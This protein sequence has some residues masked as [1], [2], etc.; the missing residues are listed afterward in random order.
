MKALQWVRRF[1]LLLLCF[2]CGIIADNAMVE[3]Q[4]PD[5]EIAMDLMDA[6][7]SQQDRSLQ[8]CNP[9][10]SGSTYNNMFYENELW[11]SPN[12]PH[13][14]IVQWDLIS[15]RLKL[16][17][18]YQYLDHWVYVWW[19]NTYN[20]Y[21]AKVFH[22]LGTAKSAMHGTL[23]HQDKAIFNIRNG[24]EYRT[25]EQIYY[26]GYQP[27]WAQY[28]ANNREVMKQV[29]IAAGQQYAFEHWWDNDVVADLLNGNMARMLKFAD[30][31]RIV[32]YKSY[33][34]RIVSKNQIRILDEGFY[35]INR[36][37]IDHAQGYRLNNDFALAQEFT[38]GTNLNSLDVCENH[39]GTDHYFPSGSTVMLCCGL[40]CTGD[41]DNDDV[42][43]SIQCDITISDC[44][45]SLLEDCV[46]KTMQCEK[47]IKSP[48]DNSNDY[49]S[50][51]SNRPEDNLWKWFCSYDCPGGTVDGEVKKIENA[52]SVEVRKQIPI[53]HSQA[54]SEGIY[55]VNFKIKRENVNVN[56]NEVLAVL[57]VHSWYNQ[58]T[59]DEFHLRKSD[60]KLGNTWYTIEKEVNLYRWDWHDI[61]LSVTGVND[62]PDLWVDWISLEYSHWTAMRRLRDSHFW[63]DFVPRSYHD[64]VS[65]ANEAGMEM[66]SIHTWIQRNTVY[67]EHVYF[68]LGAERT[69][70]WF[71]QWSDGTQLNYRF[72]DS[73]YPHIIRSAGYDDR[74]EFRSNNR[75]ATA[76]HSYH[77]RCLFQ[78]PVSSYAINN[79][80]FIDLGY[81]GTMSQCLSHGAHTYGVTL[82]SIHS[83]Q[84]NNKLI[85]LP[86][87]YHIGGA[88]DMFGSSWYWLNG[89]PWNYTNWDSSASINQPKI[90]LLPSGKWNDI[91]GNEVRKCLFRK[92]ELTRIGE[93]DFYAYGGFMTEESCK[94]LGIENNM[95]LASVHSSEEAQNIS[96]FA[97]DHNMVGY[98]G[99]NRWSSE[100]QWG[101]GTPWDY[102]NWIS[103]QP[104][105]GYI[106]MKV[107]VASGKWQN[108][109]PWSVIKCF[110]RDSPPLLEQLGYTQFYRLS[111][112]HTFK[113]CKRWSENLNMNFASIRNSWERDRINEYITRN[114]WI[115]A[116]E[117]WEGAWRWVDGSPFSY[118]NW[119]ANQP[120]NW[121]NEQHHAEISVGA[122]GKWND[123]TEWDLEDCLFY[124]HER[125]NVARGKSTEQSSTYLD[126]VSSRAVD[127]NLNGYNSGQS[128]THTLEESNPWWN[129]NLQSYYQIS[130]IRIYNRQ[131]DCCNFR[132]DGFKVEI[133]DMTGNYL[134]YSYTNPAG[135]APY[136][137]IINVPNVSGW[138]VTV[139]L[140]GNNLILSLTEVIVIGI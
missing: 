100:W 41:L 91:T 103:S 13:T 117:V 22:N 126:R 10:H 101:D 34:S 64:C 132:L 21:N 135:I 31:A 24:V 137:T 121:H 73:G 32:D 114:I 4:S 43:K 29:A 66:A 105:G 112:L 72:W 63:S 57:K 124:K 115:G 122:S 134:R 62:G 127:G 88:D 35:Y 18:R 119:E 61:A 12:M 128:V 131:D 17:M 116:Y 20:T 55:K 5:K 15:C 77:R 59:I 130:E 106:S 45:N 120:N 60:L 8:T 70:K 6:Q 65:A 81:S 107:D 102:T 133:F 68:W 2:P 97:Y 94:F 56:P 92:P 96:D 123:Q 47:V 71:Y 30:D 1:P 16:A 28:R 49:G 33:Y 36:K 52:Q 108:S 83:N 138:M 86:E 53:S 90:E 26:Y 76:H 75:L 95:T 42:M 110:L 40:Q 113:E 80:P 25:I 48:E 84:E 7:S 44:Y 58:R 14:I 93:S 82:A 99:G 19:D 50:S 89:Y 125:H 136:E 54:A 9:N 23:T 139:S 3:I 67:L 85:G 79:S 111:G 129:V 69:R 46:E 74:V 104:T 38:V 78:K 37:F 87:S 109:I 39:N 118:T 11:T 27:G 98:L 51:R 140:P